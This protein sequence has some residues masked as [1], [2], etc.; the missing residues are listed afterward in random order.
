MIANDRRSNL[1]GYLLGLSTDE[2][3]TAIEV[4]YFESPETLG[5]M[6]DEE[7]DLIDDY[8]S[9]RLDATERDAFDSHYL[10]APQHRTRVAV[11]RRLRSAATAE[12]LVQSPQTEANRRPW[13]ALWSWPGWAVSAGVVVLVAAGA[14]WMTRSGSVPPSVDISTSSRP[15]TNQA[16]TAGPPTPPVQPIV[17][18]LSISPTTVRGSGEPAMLSIPP[19]AEM[20]VL[21]LQGEVD[22]APVI[23]GRAVV[24]TVAGD[25]VWRGPAAPGDQAGTLARIE[26]R[27]RLQPEDYIVELLA[28]NPNGREVE[29]HRYFFRVRQ[30]G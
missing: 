1:R 5:R 9:G 21:R 25:E 20:V 14:V 7:D 11:A 30:S 3:R 22:D 4:E 2:K 26:I 24:R 8:L 16:R 10:A 27:L 15:D 28:R 17:I 18:T 6:C 19:S 13:F 12:P 29:R 23:G